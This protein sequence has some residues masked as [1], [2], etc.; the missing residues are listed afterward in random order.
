MTLKIEK[1]PDDLFRQVKG[2]AALEGMTLRD[3]TI[4]A[5]RVAL[6]RSAKK[7]GKE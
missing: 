5:L 7:A 1:V 4:A 2:T 3:Y 6:A